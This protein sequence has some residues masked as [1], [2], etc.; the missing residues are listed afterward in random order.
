M[1]GLLKLKADDWQ[2]KYLNADGSIRVAQLRF[3][4]SVVS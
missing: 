4:L 1:N 2:A 3:W